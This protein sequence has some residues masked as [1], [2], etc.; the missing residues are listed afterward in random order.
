VNQ[1][2]TLL[3]KAGSE[4]RDGAAQLP[5]DVWRSRSTQPT[6]GVGVALAAGIA[7]L[8]LFI[9]LALWWASG[10]EA[11]ALVGG[12][13][14]LQGSADVTVR[15]DW[16]AA[17][18]FAASFE[19]MQVALMELLEKDIHVESIGN[20]SVGEGVDGDPRTVWVMIDTTSGWDANHKQHDGAWETLQSLAALYSEPDGVWYSEAWVPNLRLTYSSWVSECSGEFMVALADSRKSRSDWDAECREGYTPSSP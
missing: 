13:P 3:E 18:S 15:A 10:D 16:A 11:P 2:D 20:V 19:S 8:V 4:F 5:D 6:I 14:V 17:D 12:S 7:V 1:I 9:P